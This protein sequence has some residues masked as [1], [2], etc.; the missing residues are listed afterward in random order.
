MPTTG[1]VADRNAP[2]SRQTNPGGKSTDLRVASE[3]ITTKEEIDIKHQAEGQ[4][5]QR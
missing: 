4:A 3:A 2:A 1:F 5:D